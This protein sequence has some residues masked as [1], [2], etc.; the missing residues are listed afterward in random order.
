[1]SKNISIGEG[2]AIGIL[3]AWLGLELWSIGSLYWRTYA[4]RKRAAQGAGHQTRPVQIGE[5]TITDLPS[6]ETISS[7]LYT[8]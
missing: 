4:A 5:V 6:G 7:P 2:V 8:C 3:V 1:M